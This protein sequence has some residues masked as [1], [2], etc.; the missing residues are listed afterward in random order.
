M[1]I[2]PARVQ[3]PLASRLLKRLLL[4]SAALILA[5]AAGLSWWEYEAAVEALQAEFTEI[6][7]TA[8]QGI[9]LSVWDFD[10]KKLDI[11]VEGIHQ[12]RL[13]SY[14]AVTGTSGPSEMLASAGKSKTRGVLEREY[15]LTV[16]RGGRPQAIGTLRIQADLYE[17]MRQAFLTGLKG[18]AF[19][20]ALVLLVAGFLFWFTNSMISRHLA[21]LALYF[22]GFSLRD[23][24]RPMVLDKKPA[25]DE[26]DV[27]AQAAG[28]MQE[29]LA[30]SYDRILKAQEQLR[31]SEDKFRTIFDSISELVYVLD[32]ET[33][34]FVDVN[35]RACEAFGFTREEIIGTEAG[36]LGEYDPPYDRAHA[37]EKMRLVL[38][39]GE[40]CFEWKS[41]KKNG[42]LFWMEVSAR[43]CRISGADRLLVSA[44]D[45]TDRKRMQEVLVQTEKMMSV[46][47]LAAGMAHEI[48]NPLS[49]ILQSTQVLQNRLF[50][51]MPASR[52]AAEEAG[53]PLE[54]VQAFLKAREVDTF[55]QTV[56]EAGSRAAKIVANMLEFSR[57]TE[58]LMSPSNLNALLEKTVELCANDYDLKKKYDFRKIEI[59]RDFDPD[60]PPVPCTATRIEQVVLNLLRNA[61]QAM[62]G[63]PPDRPPRIVLRTRE[64]KGMAHVEVEDNG[65][66]M[67]AEVRKRVFEPFFT[68]KGQGQGTGLGL[69]V[70]YF[71]ITENHKGTIEVDSTLGAGTRF[72]ICLPL[73]VP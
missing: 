55:I 30:A 53:C 59:V 9:A 21:K 19:N 37:L 16:L 69:S 6:G 56:H 36:A 68:T 60:L 1:E 32:P 7:N 39:S 29:G 38:E 3:H 11:Q 66:G 18:L 35:Q 52:A 4:L 54:S 58:S 41:K 61:A 10:T 31:L 73:A 34:T 43:M 72:T 20:S 70:S 63:N 65:P 14:V 44:R 62:R 51:E 15:P 57:T 67:P 22:Q 45:I 46:G 64:E 24:V 28:D 48:N 2:V 27:L 40:Q 26:L 42:E 71:I 12:F 50:K 13:I 49:A 25:G 23:A 5:L 33:V 8:V 47:G 17:A